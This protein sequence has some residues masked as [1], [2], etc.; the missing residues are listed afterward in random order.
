MITFLLL[1]VCMYLAGKDKWTGIFTAL[2]LLGGK[3]LFIGILS[4]AI[5]ITFTLLKLWLDKKKN[6]ESQTTTQFVISL[7]PSFEWKWKIFFAWLGGTFITV[8]S[9]VFI[10]PSGLSAAAA[11][12][13]D[14]LSGWNTVSETTALQMLAA[15][16]GY[17]LLA[18]VIGVI[19]IVKS[20]IS[21][22]Y[23]EKFL[24]WW[25][26]FALILVFVY[27]SKDV[28][29]TLW[30]LIPLW[31]L[32]ARLLSVK[33][34]ILPEERLPLLTLSFLVFILLVFVSLNSIG[35]VNQP[36][37]TS[38]INVRL[39]GIVGAITLLLLITVLV[40]WGWSIRSAVGGLKWGSLA[41]LLIW[42]LSAAW[43]SSGLGRNPWTNAWRS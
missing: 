32:A 6:Q 25:C 2:T 31:L 15:V 39:V 33:M 16:L 22:S 17:E 10:I 14:Y 18:V 23:V 12:I 30:I 26:L 36:L 13:T 42:T 35:L 24:G 43:H 8:G 7:L 28:Q 37:Q 21:H 5:V 41:F 1:A 4:F 9:L 34:Q 3:S 40:G 20:F 38:P 29:D 19:C 11:S 27:P